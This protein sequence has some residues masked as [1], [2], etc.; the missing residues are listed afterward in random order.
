MGWAYGFVNGRDVGYGVPAV[1]DK[2]DCDEKIDRG[3]AYLCGDM[4]GDEF[5]CGLYFCSRHLMYR[6][7]K[8]LDHSVQKCP[9]C[10]LYKSPYEPKSDIE[11]WVFWKLNDASWEQWRE[12]NPDEVAHL[13]QVLTNE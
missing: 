1:C 6:R 2:P 4:H 12:S 13:T 7:P 11:E 9:R 3:L 10:Y 5:G 8:E